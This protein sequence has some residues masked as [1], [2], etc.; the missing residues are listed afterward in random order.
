MFLY[1]HL[2]DAVFC[3]ENNNYSASKKGKS[4]GNHD[5]DNQGHAIDNSEPGKQAERNAMHE[6]AS[7]GAYG[8]AVDDDA[9]NKGNIND[10][11]AMR[12]AKKADERR[13]GN[14]KTK[15]AAYNKRAREKKREARLEEADKSKKAEY[16]K[17]AREKKREARLE[18]A[19]KSK[20]A[21]YNKRAREKKREAPLKEVDK[22]K[23][24][25][26]NKRAREK[27]WKAPLKE[28]DK[29]KKAEY[30]KR[31]NRKKRHA[32]VDTVDEE[33]A[34]KRSKKAEDN[35]RAR[36][37][38]RNSESNEEESK[39]GEDGIHY[40]AQSDHHLK[41]LAAQEQEDHEHR[42][43][44]RRIYA[45]QPNRMNEGVSGINPRVA[46]R[47]RVLTTVG[48]SRSICPHCEAKIWPGEE[49]DCCDSGARVLPVATWPDTPEFREYIDLFK[50]RGFVNNTRRYNALFAFTSI[51]TKE[52]IHGNG[53][54]RSYTI[55]GE[56]HHSIGPMLPADEEQASYAQ[57]YITDPET[58]ASIR[59]RMLGGN[60]NQST[61]TKIQHLLLQH[62]AFTQLYK[63]AKD[64]PKD[65]DMRLVLT[66][67]PRSNSRTHDLPTCSEIAVLF[68]ET[69][70]SGRHILLHG[71][72]GPVLSEV[73]PNYRVGKNVCLDRQP[74][75]DHLFRIKEF[76][77]AYDPLQYPLLFPTGTLGWSYGNNSGLNGK[78]VSLNNYA[79]YH[80]YERGAFSPLHASGPLL[81]M[82]AVDNFAKVENPRLG[83]L[84][85]QTNNLRS[86]TYRAVHDAVSHDVDVNSIGK[87][88]VLP[89]SYT[90]GPR[91]M[92]Q[93]YLDAMAIVR[94]YGRPDLFITVTCNPKWVEIDRELEL[95]KEDYGF[96]RP[97]SDRPD[98]LTRMFRLKLLA[99]EAMLT[100]GILGRQ[101]AHVRSVEFQKRGLPRAHILVIFSG[102]DKIKTTADIDSII[103]AEIPDKE[104]NPRL[105]KIVTTC[106]IH[107]CSDRCL[108]N[109]KCKKNFPKAYRD[110]TSI[111]SDGYPLYRRRRSSAE[112]P[113]EYTNQY[114]IP[115]CPTLSAMFDCHINVEACTS[116]SAVKYLYKYI[117]KGS[118]RSNFQLES[119]KLD[120]IKQYQDARYVSCCEAL[121][122]IFSFDMFNRSHAVENL[123]IHLEGEQVVCIPTDRPMS[124]QELARRNRTKLT[125]FLNCAVKTVIHKHGRVNVC[126]MI[127]P[128]ISY[129]TQISASGL[130][131]K[132]V[133]LPQLA[134][135]EQYFALEETNRGRQSN[136]LVAMESSHNQEQIQ[137]ILEGKSTMTEEHEVFYNDVMS[138]ITK[139]SNVRR[140]KVYFLEGEG[141][142]GK[143]FISNIL[144]AQVRSMNKI[145]LAVAS[146]GLA[147][148]NL[149][150]GTTAHSRFCLPR[151]LHELSRC[152]V[153]KQSHLAELLRLTEL[154]IWDE[155][156]MMHKYA[157]EAV[158]HM[159][160]DLMDN[161]LPF[162]GKVVIF[163][164]DF[165]QMLPVI[166]KGTPGLIL[167]ACLKNSYLWSNVAKFHLTVNM[168]LTNNN[169]ESVREFAGL[170]KS[171]GHGTYPTCTELGADYI[172]LPDDL[173]IPYN[174]PDDL[175]SF[176]H[177]VYQDMNNLRIN[178]LRSYFG[179]RAILAPKHNVVADINTTL[180]ERLSSDGEMTY[181]SA[182][183]VAEKRDS[184]A[185]ACEFPIEFLNSID[186]NNFPSHKLHLKVGCPIILLRNLCTSEGMCNGTRL[187]VLELKTRYIKAQIMN[188]SHKNKIV[189]IPRTTTIH[190]G[191]QNNYPFELRRRQ[192]PVQVAFAM[193]IHKA[194]GQTISHVGVYLPEPVFSHG[195]LYVAMSRAQAKGTIN[196][197]V[198]NGQYEGLPGIYTRNVVF[199]EALK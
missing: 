129:G 92:R 82:F 61:V 108:E 69:S 30:N 78:N 10:E 99:I 150:G 114:V 197:L 14:G 148:L 193:T 160:Q 45:L 70:K 90:G 80:L 156:S 146:S 143:T 111:G 41:L 20:K 12:K 71:T 116:I 141:G 54:P 127:S 154:I 189:Y 85:D 59:R 175:G 152:D 74:G 94:K 109:G 37:K 4:N 52:I 178:E 122:R 17:R 7:T 67:Q 62:N 106:M 73:V 128:S 39:E 196:F 103:S 36:E 81:Q 138:E 117:F 187:I 192:F 105:H 25:E 180:L 89:S 162:G 23:K 19:D 190:D 1:E 172:R 76:H 135:F 28:V 6:S 159:L 104:K 144:L 96:K 24:A 184:D 64:I 142:S 130:H 40:H 44:N 98:L 195:Q 132:R 158:D 186:I 21:E 134:Q 191:E 145:A 43:D 38:K 118:D 87:R 13:V 119:S 86:D 126:T 29:S 173:A 75:E 151:S 42:V 5:N 164:G 102:D 115:Y 55:Q 97:P 18:E 182:D 51:G 32:I 169:S 79:R 77:S 185:D 139:E 157:V 163:S 147:A 155:C 56:L 133:E 53:G 33:V 3:V 66:A 100:K 153:R 188:G 140:G 27:K 181:L 110:E 11:G 8:M 15:K 183:S 149:I 136:R 31:A 49:K 125:A 120:E 2:S 121:T 46:R 65:D 16:N 123:E 131:V 174:S 168:R 50:T 60:L 83:F 95:A 91:Y 57:I 179:C 170:L 176:L 88:I 101:G 22:S 63:H 177:S 199:Q 167:E 9:L 124:P 35:K 198:A 72:D 47:R 165:K 113:S 171:I 93:R 112:R 161:A 194:Q 68:S 34:M 107:K 137:G 58:Q 26:Y 48:A 84:R 166:L